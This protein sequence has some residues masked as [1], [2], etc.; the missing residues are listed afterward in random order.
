M[1]I[2][3]IGPEDQYAVYKPD[4]AAEIPVELVFRRK[5]QP[6]VEAAQENPDVEILFVDATTKIGSDVMDELPGLKMIHTVGVGYNHVDGAAARERGIYVCNNKA[7]NADSV[8]EHAIM[9][10]LMALRAGISGHQAVV[11][12]RQFQTK[13][14]TI[15][16]RRPGLFQ[17]SVGLVGFGDIAQAAARRLSAFGCTLYYYTAHRRPPEVEAA[18]GVTYLPLEELV[19]TCDIISLHC[20]VNE[21]TRGMVNGAFLSKMKGDAV[22]V[23]CARGDLIDNEALREA[24][25]QGRIACAALDTIEPEPTPGDHPLV[26][27]PEEARRR[28]VYSPH[29]G[30]SSSGAFEKAHRTMWHNAKRILDGERPI[31]VVNGI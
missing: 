13:L 12:G 17:C 25:I 4:F 19:E 24:L 26:D 27:L 8:A 21:R 31:Y 3:V 22:L 30:G 11:E 23:N 9:L 28:V 10:M 18:F 6:P 16:A 29:L 7:C 15:A 20:A 1:K 2:L 14:E 5:D